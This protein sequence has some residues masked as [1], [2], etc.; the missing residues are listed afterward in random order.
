MGNI[1]YVLLTK[2]WPF[3]GMKDKPAQHEVKKGRPPK[4]ADTIRNSMDP[5]TQVLIKA[6]ELC[7]T[8][9]PVKRPSAR[10]VESFLSRSLKAISKA[11]AE[12]PESPIDMTLKS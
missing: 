1:F 6:A 3:E 4:F 11:K 7:W 8:Y 9:D 5:Y 2:E 12:S 10:Q